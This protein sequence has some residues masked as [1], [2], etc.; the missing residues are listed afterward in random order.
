MKNNKLI[1]ILIIFT[2]IFTACG[3]ALEEPVKDSLAPNFEAKTLH[4]EDINLAALRGKP[5]MLNFWATWCAPCRL[6]MPAI[7]SRHDLYSDE[8]VVLAINFDE[9]E[10]LVQAFEI[11]LGLTMDI[12]MDPAAKIQNLYQIRG[13]PT[14]IF[15][16]SE[17]IIQNIH[18]GIL[19]EP[20]L[21]QYLAVIGIGE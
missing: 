11:E 3:D 4:G 8:L 2:L 19:T 14:S 16:D 12:V 21:D 13:Y 9:P 20:Q 5:V 17:G 10:E 15:I 1:L 18:I 6:E 7:Q